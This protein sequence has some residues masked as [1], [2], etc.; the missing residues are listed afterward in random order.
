MPLPGKKYDVKAPET[1]AHETVIGRYF[2][3]A[4]ATVEEAVK[5]EVEQML[6]DTDLA[7][8]ETLL[9]EHRKAMAYVV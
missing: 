8:F 3:Y 5:R 9:E 2:L 7:L 4:A 1:V 6:I